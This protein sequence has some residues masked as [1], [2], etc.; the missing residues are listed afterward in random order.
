[1]INLVVVVYNSHCFVAMCSVCR[2]KIWWEETW[3]CGS[4]GAQAVHRSRPNCHSWHGWAISIFIRRKN[5]GSLW[6]TPE[7]SGKRKR[8]WQ[9]RKPRIW[10][11]RLGPE[12]GFQIES[13]QDYWS[14]RRGH[15]EESPRLGSCPIRGSHGKNPIIMFENSTRT[16]LICSRHSVDWD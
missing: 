6:I 5:P 7:S 10:N 3:G 15:N 9:G 11:T 1:M 4:G 14:V 8:S 16:P 12:Q 2:R 13:S